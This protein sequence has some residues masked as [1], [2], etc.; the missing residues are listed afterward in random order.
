[1]ISFSKYH[2]FPG[3]GI[4]SLGSQ[5]S[6]ELLLISYGHCFLFPKKSSKQLIFHPCSMPSLTNWLCYRVTWSLSQGSLEDAELFRKLGRKRPHLSG[7]TH[8]PHPTLPQ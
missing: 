7:T 2:C 4:F 3:K 8:T 6:T 1:V 5:K